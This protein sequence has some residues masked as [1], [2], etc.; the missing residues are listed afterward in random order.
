M[1]TYFKFVCIYCGQHMECKP[2]LCGRQMLC[3]ACDHRIVIPM[4]PENPAAVRHVSAPDT[5]DT[6]VPTP[7]VET[8][9]RYRHRLASNP[10]LAQAA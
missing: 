4:M 8:P 3:P 2:R 5:W 1:N 9:T 10:V 7:K 6:A